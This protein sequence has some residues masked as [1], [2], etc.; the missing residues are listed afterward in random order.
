MFNHLELRSSFTGN[1]IPVEYFPILNCSSAVKNINNT[2]DG[3]AL[4]DIDY[5]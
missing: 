2:C 1:C 3:R 4:D 5:G